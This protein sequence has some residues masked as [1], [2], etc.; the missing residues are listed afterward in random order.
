MFASVVEMET[1]CDYN[2][3]IETLKKELS[4]VWLV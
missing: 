3:C 4:P 1:D 2:K